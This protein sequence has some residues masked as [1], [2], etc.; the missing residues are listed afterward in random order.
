MSVPLPVISE[1]NRPLQLA[2]VGNPNTG[3]TTL[4]NALTGLRQRIGNYPGITVS[5]ATGTV[6]LEKQVAY[7]TD[8]PGTYSL[9]ASSP[10]E[11]IVHD[12]I[13]GNVPNTARPDVLV[14]VVDATNLNKNL[15]LVS[16]LAEHNIPIV[17]AMS[18]WDSAMRLKTQ[19]QI[20]MLSKRLGVPVIPINVVKN[21]GIAELKQAI[22]SAHQHQYKMV[23]LQWEPAMAAA[24]EEFCKDLE[25][26]QIK[27]NTAEAH[28]LIFDSTMPT[29]RGIDAK[30]AVLRTAIDSC[31]TRIRKAG[32]HPHTVEAVLHHRHL[33][34]LI[35][36]VILSKTTQ[37]MRRG[38]I[39]RSPAHSQ[40]LGHADFCFFHV[41]GVPVSPTPGPHRSWI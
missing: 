40:I 1:S 10:D 6:F 23:R 37:V 8:L 24:I 11:K 22:L 39:H 30:S 35:D 31:R 36:G 19:L 32:Y 12:Y 38:E 29:L 25:K 21:E 33:A 26:Q 13:N 9:A 20:E 5:M 27:V 28:R 3:K 34:E 17:I 2:L 14:S 4:F 16:Q 15:Y 18:F 7:I 41:S